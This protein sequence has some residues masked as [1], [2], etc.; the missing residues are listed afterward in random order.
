METLYRW[1]SEQDIFCERLFVVYGTYLLS[2]LMAA[3][4]DFMS[5]GRPLHTD[6]APILDTLKRMILKEEQNKKL[7][8]FIEVFFFKATWWTRR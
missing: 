4:F 3:V 6:W 1:L 8:E 2:D 7:E 5:I